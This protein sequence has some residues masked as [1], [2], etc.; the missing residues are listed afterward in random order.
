M[1][2]LIL[3]IVGVLII[4]MATSTYAD[5]YYEFSAYS[6]P[7]SEYDVDSYG[8]T[9]YY[10]AGTQVYA[11]D[12]SI[13]DMTKKDEPYYLADGVTLN[14]NYQKR[15]FSNNR[16]IDLTGAPK[17]LYGGSWGEMYVDSD[18]I[19]TLGY[20]DGA[21]YAFNRTTGAYS[22]TAFAGGPSTIGDGWGNASFLGYGG[23]K[24][25]L[26]NED[27]EVYSSSSGGW[28]FEFPWNDMTPG[29]GG[30]DHGDG[31]E[32]VNGHVFVSDMTSNHIAMWDYD[33]TDWVEAKVFDYDEIFGGTAKY[34][35]GMGFGALDH[36]WAGSGSHIYELGGGSIQNYIVPVPGAVL[37]GLLGLGA[38]GMKLRRFA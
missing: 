6:G 13:A 29:V 32:Y 37:L 16:H 5:I 10:G 24:W 15:T 11:V 18:Y 19:Y 22:H 2:K 26:G 7:G 33:G 3:P 28:V 34:V 4:N 27:R 20:D 9:I 21:V 12:V 36:F 35:E 14:T 25:W 8:N 30:L 38:A 17:N 31:M 1:K 23:G